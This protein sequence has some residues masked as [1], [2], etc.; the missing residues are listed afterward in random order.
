[1]FWLVQHCSFT[2]DGKEDQHVTELALLLVKI[3]RKE[4]NR[5]SCYETVRLGLELQNCVCDP[6]Y[7]EV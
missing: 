1:M 5:K 2:T 6:S 3:W 7:L 4:Q